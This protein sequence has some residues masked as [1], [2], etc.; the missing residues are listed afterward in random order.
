MTPNLRDFLNTLPF[1]DV[2][3]LFIFIGLLV[4]M[5]FLFIH[6]VWKV[7]MAIKGDK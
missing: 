1:S 6:A 3:D 5:G 2:G 4:V 7:V